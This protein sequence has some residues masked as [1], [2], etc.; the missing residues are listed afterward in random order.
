MIQSPRS[1]VNTKIN[2]NPP[3][4]AIQD[5]E[6]QPQVPEVIIGFAL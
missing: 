3:K 5:P 1:K 4:I 2:S 6:P